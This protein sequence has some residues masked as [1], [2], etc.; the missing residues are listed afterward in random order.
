MRLIHGVALVESLLLV[1]LTVSCQAQPVVETIELKHVRADQVTG[2]FAPAY[3]AGEEQV[4]A[5]HERVAISFALDAFARVAALRPLEEA[6]VLPVE[7]ACEALTGE[8][9]GWAMRPRPTEEAPGR[10]AAL[11]PEGL[12]GLP[13]PAPGVNALIV[14]GTPEAIDEFR[15]IVGL[16]DTPPTAAEVEVALHEVAASVLEEMLPP[17]AG[18][19][20]SQRIG[21]HL[22][23]VVT[24][25]DGIGRTLTSARVRVANGQAAIVSLAEVLPVLGAEATVWYDAAGQ[26]HEEYDHDAALAG[27][28]VWLMPLIY[29]DD[30]VAMELRV[31]GVEAHGKAAAVGAEDVS[32][33]E[34]VRMRCLIRDGEAA[35]LAKLGLRQRL[36]ELTQQAGIEDV[37][38][39]EALDTIITITPRAVTAPEG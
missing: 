9:V 2:M 15:E 30:T 17:A 26:R 27:I 6:Q 37:S 18:D 4:A 16:L 12:E 34:L 29:P 8:R 5:S 39:G 23:P 1:C 36:N 38:L 35:L 25:P 24:G 22:G 28:S 3:E 13:E 21:L 11:L 14:K 7:G 32:V 33:R 19:E 20:R 31:L 10:A